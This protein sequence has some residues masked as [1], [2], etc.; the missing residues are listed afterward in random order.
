LNTNRRRR[1]HEPRARYCSI[2]SGSSSSSSSSSN[3]QT[4]NTDKRIAG[5][6]GSV[7]VSGDSSTVTVTDAGAVGLAFGFARDAA[8]DAYDYAA[9]SATQSTRVLTSAL[10]GVEKS[11]DDIKAAYSEAKAGD[12]KVLVAGGLI[13]A[14]IVAVAALKGFR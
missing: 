8:R 1:R 10:E 4:Y 9:G 13:V 14:G 3:Q 12:Q 7:N 5:G 6:P 11:V 2:D